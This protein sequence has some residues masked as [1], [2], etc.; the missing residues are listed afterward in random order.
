M[1]FGVCNAAQTFQCFIHDATRGLEFA[2]SYLD[3]IL[4]GSSSEQ[5]HL[6]HLRTLFQRLTQHGITVNPTKCELR[7]STADFLGHLVSSCGIEVH[8]DNIQAI[9][10]FPAPT[11]C[12]HLHR[13]CGLVNYYRRFIPRCAQLMQPLTDLLRGNERKFAFP[14]TAQTAF[15]ELK[16]AIS[17][18]ALLAHSKST[19]PL[20]ITTNALNVAVGSVLQQHVGGQWQPLGFFSKRLKPAESR[21]STFGRELLAI[22]LAIRHFR[23]TLESRAFT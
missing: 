6:E 7:K 10:D 13:F 18:I 8:P 17:N 23:H 16:D 20:S 11:S 19:A 1:P 9:K 22:Y 2:Y 14:G 15:A 4:V 12:K 5:E 3:D 21:Y